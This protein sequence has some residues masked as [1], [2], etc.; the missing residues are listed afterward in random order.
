MQYN[1][2]LLKEENMKSTT[3]LRITAALCSGAMLFGAGA[4]GNGS[5]SSDDKVIEWWDDWTRHEDGSEFDKLVKECAPEGYTIERQAIATSD[6]LNNLT[7]AI[8]EDNG[9]DVAVIDNPMIPSAVDA[10]LV[11]GSGESGLDVSAWDENLEAPG[12]VDGEAYGVPL[13]GSN[14]LGLMYNPDI[15]EAAGVDVTAITDWDSLNDA[16]SKVVDAGYKGITFSGISGE[17]GV[18]QFLPWFWGAG[19][20]LSDIESQAKDDAEALLSSWISKGWAPK[21]ATTNT[22]S[23]SWDLFLAG[24]YGFAEIGTWMQTE[25]DEAGAKMIPIPAKD[26]GVA[27]VPT[28]GEFAMVAYHKK[29]ADSH[30]ELAN[31]VIECLS[32]PDTLLK[33]SNALSNLAAKKE[34][35]DQQLSDSEGL[36]QWKESIE[37]A[38]GRTSDL[39]L[40]Y[41]EASASLSES[42]LKALNN[43]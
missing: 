32:E 7:T 36:A 17:E 29:N 40:T 41:E 38:Q 6:L 16:I 24:D 13:G 35:R 5:A 4:C 28:G 20:D 3:A 18:F 37:N 39:G 1:T 34:V 25:A 26:G 14:T 12:V 9:P 30:Y 43:A 2:D 22:Q 11:A 33:V 10:G 31:Q 42:L 19:G 21:S 23:T 8:K 15:I 27:P